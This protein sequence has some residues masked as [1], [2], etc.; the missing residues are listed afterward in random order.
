MDRGEFIQGLASFSASLLNIVSGLLLYLYSP[1]LD[2]GLVIIL[3]MMLSFRGA[4]TGIFSGGYSS[5][6]HLG[7]MYPGLR[8]NTPVF[9]GHL[10]AVII[11]SYIVVLLS[12]LAGSAAEYVLTGST[13][14]ARIFLVTSYVV[15]LSMALTLPINVVLGAVIFRRGWDPDIMLYPVA[16]NFSDVVTSLLLVSVTVMHPEVLWLV[17]ALSL[18]LYT[19]LAIRLYSYA[20]RG[21]VRRGVAESLLSLLMVALS[22]GMGGFIL[23]GFWETLVDRPYIYMVVPAILSLVGSFAAALASRATTLLHL[24]EYIGSLGVVSRL[25]AP[26]LIPAA[27]VAGLS[28]SPVVIVAH[29]LEPLRLLLSSIIAMTLL[30]VFSLV[31][32]IAVFMRGLDPDNLVIPVVTSLSDLAAIAALILVS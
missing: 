9:Y 14:L 21:V 32:S 19:L 15:I 1:G 7:S 28:V 31:M 20:E 2:Q 3:P 8:R 17:A 30:G 4:L 5:G 25:V 29:P 11:D 10:L 18:L 6:L 24:G 27:I 13:D 16:S 26:L 12:T 23:G 22:S